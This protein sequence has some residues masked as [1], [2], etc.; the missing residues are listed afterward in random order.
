MLPV[1][2]PLLR[3][4]GLERTA[5]RLGAASALLLSLLFVFFRLL[6]R[7]LRLCWRFRVTCRRLRCFPQPPRRSWLLGHLGMVCAGQP[8][9]RGWAGPGGSGRRVHLLAP[10]VPSR[11]W[12]EPRADPFY[13][14]GVRL[15]LRED[16]SLPK[17]TQL[18]GRAASQVLSDSRLLLEQQVPGLVGSSGAGSQGGQQERCSCGVVAPSPSPGWLH[19]LS[20]ALMLWSQVKTPTLFLH[21]ICYFTY[22]CQILF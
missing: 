19:T 17:V 6:L 15:R 20:F 21:F 3:L 13:R 11:I 18:G 8:G 9:G 14:V 7:F 2:E 12:L 10:L 16:S 22:M 5:F 1:A 4:L